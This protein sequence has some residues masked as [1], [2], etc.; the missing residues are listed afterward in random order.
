MDSG[1]G[2]WRVFHSVCCQVTS[3]CQKSLHCWTSQAFNRVAETKQ[4]STPSSNKV[5]LLVLLTCHRMS[6]I[7]K[8][9]LVEKTMA[10]TFRI[11]R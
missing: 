1:L 5:L 2:R 11:R 7:N 10:S 6:R 3:R 9:P 4:S 8:S